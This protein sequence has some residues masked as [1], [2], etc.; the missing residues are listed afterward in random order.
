MISVRLGYDIRSG[1]AGQKRRS[2]CQ[3]QRTGAE[4]TNVIP[5]SEIALASS[6]NTAEPA[7][8]GLPAA[9]KL[10]MN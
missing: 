10:S 4:E 6:A 5:L 7:Q 8:S 2:Q 1:P 3:S 9:G